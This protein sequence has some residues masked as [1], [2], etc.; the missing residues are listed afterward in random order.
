MRCSLFVI[1]LLLSILVAAQSDTPCPCCTPQHQQFDFWVG[2]WVVK[3]TNGIVLGENT[4]TSL[5]NGCLISE[6]WRGAGGGTGR[7]YNYFDPLDSTWNQLWVSSRGNILR[8][9]GTATEGQM[10]LTGPV[11]D[12]PK[13]PYL[14]RITWTKQEDGTVVQQ[15]DLLTPD[16]TWMRTAFYGIYYPKTD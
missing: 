13:G 9:K 8:L 15:W 16:G 3:D 1:G 4:I 12:N 5:E 2:D 14:D 11:K 6:Y 10:T 7:S